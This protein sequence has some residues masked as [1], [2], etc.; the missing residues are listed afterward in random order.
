MVVMFLPCGEALIT[1]ASILLRVPAVNV[2]QLDRFASRDT[3]RGRG[4]GGPTA[5]SPTTMAEGRLLLLSTLVLLLLLLLLLALSFLFVLL[6]D[7]LQTGVWD[8]EA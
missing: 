3:M 6:S 5:R 4:E 1:P 8:P 2:P 7:P